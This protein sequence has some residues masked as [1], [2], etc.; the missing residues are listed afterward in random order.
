MFILHAAPARMVVTMIDTRSLSTL[1]FAATLLACAEPSVDEADYLGVSGA[2]LSVCNETVPATRFIDGVPSYAQCDATQ[3]SAIYSN[4]G[5]DTSLTK[6]GAD[7]VRTQGSGGYQCTELAG[8]YLTF[9]W[10]VKWRPNGNAGMWCD[11]APPASSGIVQTMTPSHGDIMVLAGGSCGAAAETGHVNVVDTVDTAKGK[12]SAVEQNGARRGSYNISCAKC[13]LHVV[14][15]DGTNPGLPI[16]GAA[17][18]AGAAGAAPGAGAAGAAPG[19]GAAGAS[20]PPVPP[21]AAGGPAPAPPSDAAPA[22]PAGSPAPVPTPPPAATKPSPP[23]TSLPAS[24]SHAAGSNAAVT[25]GA[26]ASTPP[27]RGISDTDAEAGGCTI[28]RAAGDNDGGQVIVLSLRALS[29]VQLR[30][31]RR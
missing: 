12:L 4:N 22:R 5:V 1:V 13:F 2:A 17:P 3:N 18:G 25:A 8:R 31:R 30:R 7:W 19:A 9:K 28:Q 20:V 16:T 23:A 24:G 29:L 10:G 14:A 27:L 21:T 6:V 11:T 26:A 15:N